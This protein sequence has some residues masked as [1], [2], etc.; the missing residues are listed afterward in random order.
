M[1]RESINEIFKLLIIPFLLLLAGCKSGDEA[2][3]FSGDFYNYDKSK[4]STDIVDDILQC[5][6]NPPL[7]WL[8]QSAELSRKV[9]SKNKFLDSSQNTFTYSPL[10]LFFNENTGSLL[11]VGS[12]DYSDPTAAVELRI[13]NYRN[14]IANKFRN[15]KLSVGSFSKSG[16]K[17]T[18]LKSEKE[19]IVNYKI[20]FANKENK[21]IQFDCTIRKDYMD[22]ELDYL[23]A[24]I[25]SIQLLH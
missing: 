15:D 3:W 22:T 7:N 10:Y 24:A 12:V 13:N 11:S 5:K 8:F 6:F 21:I 23:K 14:M 9:E 17:F 20:L 18:Q 19:S 16:I 2:D 4:I 25:G 1:K